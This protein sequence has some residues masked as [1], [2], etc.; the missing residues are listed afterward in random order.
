MKEWKETTSTSPSGRHLG[1]YKTAL[2]DNRVTV[3]HVAM[4]NLPIMYGFVPEHWTH[5]ITPLIEKDEGKPFLTRLRVIN[6]FKADYSLFLKVV[7]GKQLV[8]NAEKSNALNDQQ[9][10]SRSRW[11]T[12]DALFLARLEKDLIRQTKSNSAHMENDATGCYE[13]IVTSVGMMASR[14]LGTTAHATRCH[15]ESL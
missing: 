4:L 2:L 9:H 1:H 11:M 8:R 5:S 12:T 15:A 14:R 3:L 13:R 7:Y 10:G 6:L